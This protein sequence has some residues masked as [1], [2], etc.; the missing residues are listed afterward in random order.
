[1]ELYFKS[2]DNDKINK[3]W[4]RSDTGK[5]IFPNELLRNGNVV[6]QLDDNV[7]RA[8]INMPDGKTMYAEFD[9]DSKTASK[10]L[11]QKSKYK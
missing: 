2:R 7:T 8:E 9:V 1:M 5:T 10:A 6:A 4:T 11:L 3:T